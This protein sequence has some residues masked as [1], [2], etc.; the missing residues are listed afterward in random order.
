ME[1]QSVTC[2]PTQ[3][4]TPHLN[5]SQT[6][7]YGSLSEYGDWM[8]GWMD[9]CGVSGCGVGSGTDDGVDDGFVSANVLL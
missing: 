2:H 9:G 8:D 6:G 1:S 4:N 5:P 3:V 7:R